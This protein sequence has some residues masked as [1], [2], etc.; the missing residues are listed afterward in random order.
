MTIQLSP[1]EEALA[2]DAGTAELKFLFGDKV[3]LALQAKFYHSGITT[4][5]LFASL[6][7]DL[8]DL[9]KML[10]DDMGVDGTLS[11]A[12]RVIVA[13]VIVAFGKAATRTTELS[14]FDAEMEA[15]RLPKALATSE[16]LTM[17]AAWEK[18]YWPLEDIDL[19]GRS[20]LERRLEEL[21]SGELRAESLQTVLSREGDEH[22]YLQPVWDTSGVLKVRKA[23]AMV[24][25]PANPEQLRRRLALSFT[26]LMFLGFRHTH[27]PSLQNITPQLVQHYAEYLL[28]EFVW[29]LVA[30]DAQGQII[31]TPTWDLITS[32]NMAIRRQHFDRWRRGQ[33]H[34]Q[35]ASKKQ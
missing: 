6:V 29:G 11:M 20:Y 21:E 4:I 33:G 23:G 22:D 30:K 18:A 7:K 10:K 25:D 9:R 14:K 28:G 2:L 12:N 5:E 34:S 8:E 16:Y 32:Y 15:K 31:S 24:S 27:R 17:K 19:P 13:A 26:G 35:P 1:A 3:P